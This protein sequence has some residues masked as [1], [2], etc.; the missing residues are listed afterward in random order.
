M[1]SKKSLSK[2]YNLDQMLRDTDELLKEAS[3][4]FP[5]KELPNE[6]REKEREQKQERESIFPPQTPNERKNRKVIK[7]D[8]G[9]QEG[10][11]KRPSF[12]IHIKELSS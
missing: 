6:E 8:S 7:D 11:V 5:K 12:Y 2:T 3:I 9:K 1:L 10:S 4:F